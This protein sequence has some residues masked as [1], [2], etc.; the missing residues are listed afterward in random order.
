M[1]FISHSNLVPAG[2]TVLTREQTYELGKALDAI[3]K[4][5][6]NLYGQ[7]SKKWYGM[8]VEFN[9]DGEEGETPKLFVKQ[10]RPHPGW[11]SD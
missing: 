9:F 7:D 4:H 3:H 2:D 8:D 11:G 1:V 6:L 5:F 10:A